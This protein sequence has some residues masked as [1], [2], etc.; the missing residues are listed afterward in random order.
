MPYMDIFDCESH[1]NGEVFLTSNE[2]IDYDL[3]DEEEETIETLVAQHFFS[4]K[5]KNCIDVIKEDLK[6]T[7]GNRYELCIICNSFESIERMSE[8]DFIYNGKIYS[9]TL[10]CDDCFSR[11]FTYDF[12]EKIYKL[13]K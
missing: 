6:E 8:R 11:L 9:D 4:N 5:H 1:V 10:V 2:I 7:D 12:N 13:K 3:I